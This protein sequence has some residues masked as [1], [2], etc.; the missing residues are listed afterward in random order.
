MKNKSIIITVVLITILGAVMVIYYGNNKKP[1]AGDIKQSK[2]SKSEI[3]SRDGLHWHSTLSIYIKG[4]KLEIPQNVGLGA[5]HNPIHTHDEDA[6]DGIIHMEFG[7]LV[8]AGDTMLG[9]F[10]KVWNK[11][12]RSFGVN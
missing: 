9:N 5:I 1:S 3:I 7:G 4:E 8:R 2:D 10:F 11:D 12:M 6:S